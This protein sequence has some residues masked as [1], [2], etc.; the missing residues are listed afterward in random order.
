MKDTISRLFMEKNGWGLV[1]VMLIEK[2]KETHR[3]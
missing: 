1:F 3:R 2:E